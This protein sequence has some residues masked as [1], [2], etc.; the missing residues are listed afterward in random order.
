M[1][2]AFAGAEQ[3]VDQDK[4]AALNTLATFGRQG[5]EQVV[6]N[7][8]R[9]TDAQRNLA[10]QN[11]KL[12]WENR[13]IT[14]H[15]GLGQNQMDALA[16]IGAD[17]TQAYVQDAGDAQKFLGSEQGMAQ[18]V[19]AGYYDQV[20]QAVPGMRAEAGRQADEYR[21]AYEQRQA[22]FAAQQQ[23]QQLQRQEALL[24]IQSLQDERTARDAEAA[25]TPEAKAAR[26]AWIAAMVAKN[27]TPPQRQRQRV[28]G[29]TL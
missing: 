27:P 11:V 20:R 25:L 21:A 22:D 14:L 2:D 1:A 9:A 10:T 26:A 15:R 6:L 17:S 19:N 16:K 8:K 28:G 29:F 7:K 12:P 5:M 24:S 23:A 4:M 18:K 13:G 3:A